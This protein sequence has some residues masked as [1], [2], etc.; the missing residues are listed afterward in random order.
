MSTS[1]DSWD[2]EGLSYVTVPE[3]GQVKV[4]TELGSERSNGVLSLP[5]LLINLI[6]FSCVI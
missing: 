5:P 6:F 2:L 3:Y 1:H 4:M